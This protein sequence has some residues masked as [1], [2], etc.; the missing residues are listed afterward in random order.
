M[1][2]LLACEQ[3]ARQDNADDNQQV[4]TEQESPTK[5]IETLVGEWQLAEGGQQQ[6]DE[7]TRQQTDDQRSN[8][9]E[10]AGDQTLEF[11]NEARYILRE[12]EQK[13]DSGAYRMNEQLRNLYLESE[14]NE[15]PREFEVELRRDT[16]I[17]TA[18]DEQQEQG[19]L[20]E[21]VWVRRN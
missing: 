6:Q 10:Q 20:D 19:A 5:M 8:Q 15:D 2:T 17:L 13:T 16:L 12:G 7:A 3:R 1:L 9:Q 18:R 21:Q 11:T 14:A 4:N